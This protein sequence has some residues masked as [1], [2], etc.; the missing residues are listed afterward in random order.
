MRRL[1]ISLLLFATL[2]FA[3]PVLAATGKVIKVLPHFLDLKGHHAKSP[4]LFDRDAYQAWLRQNP[5]ERSGIQYDVQWRAR[6]ATGT[7][8]LRLELRGIAE[9]SLPRQKTIETELKPGGGTARWDKLALQGDDY[10]TFGEVTAWRVTLWDGEQ[11]IDEQ[12]SY[13]W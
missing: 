4:S 8:K 13:L 2:A 6:E 7:M 5:N 9:G 10:K 1:F 12:T 11:L 3:F